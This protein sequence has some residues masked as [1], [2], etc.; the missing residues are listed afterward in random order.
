MICYPGDV[1]HPVREIA[2]PGMS[3][4]IFRDGRFEPILGIEGLIG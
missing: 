4:L 2:F 1:A 3:R